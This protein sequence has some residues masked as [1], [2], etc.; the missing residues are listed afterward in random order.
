MS[1][2]SFH[3]PVANATLR[4][5]SA[6]SITQVVKPCLTHVLAPCIQFVDEG[7]SDIISDDAIE[8]LKQVIGE[9]YQEKFRLSESLKQ[10]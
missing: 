3:H 9:L 10:G 6:I 5:P 8:S 7:A 1:R 2:P 4:T